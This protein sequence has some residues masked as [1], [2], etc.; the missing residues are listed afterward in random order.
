[1]NSSQHVDFVIAGTQKG[2]TTALDHYL[3]QHP[4]IG[5]ASQKE[6]HYFDN[7]AHFSQS[8]D[9][10]VYHGFFDWDDG[11]RVHGESTPVYMYW[12]P[13]PVRMQ[14][15]SASLKIILSLRNPVE[16]A[17]SHWNMERGRGNDDMPFMEAIEQE[18]TRC[19]EAV[20]GQ[21]RVFSYTDR[22]FYSKQIRRILDHFP[23]EQLLVIRH[24]ALRM[25]P[26]S[27][28]ATVTDFLGVAPLRHLEPE[29]VF[30]TTYER[31]MTERERDYLRELY[32]EE[33][34]S[35]E[36]LLGWD[37]TAWRS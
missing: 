35:L 12:H 28:M 23:L 11:A 7:E 32:R 19:R 2:G 17:F 24:E 21:H 8:P 4:D 16:R 34:N 13:A 33:V 1:M 29:D 9:Y 22:G 14:A 15:Y 18:S 37:L 36:A 30:P 25:A 26:E 10:S 31:Q 3:R 6:V 5:M 20:N 27:T